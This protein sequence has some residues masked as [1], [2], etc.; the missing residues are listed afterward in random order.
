MPEKRGYLGALICAFALLAPVFAAHLTFVPDVTFKGASLAGWHVLGDA[1][2]RAQD[3]ELIGKA[4]AGSAGGWLVLDNPYQDVEVN[5]MFQCTG[6][7]RTGLL[8]RLE[9]TPEGYQGVLVSLNAG[10]VAPYQLTLDENGKEVKREELRNASG[11][12]RVAPPLD[13]N[14]AA[15][16]AGNRQARRRAEPVKLPLDLRPTE[17][18]P[19]EWNEVDVVMDANI[20]RIALNNGGGRAGVTDAPGKQFGPVA[21]FVGGTGEVRFKEFSYRDLAMQTTPLEKVSS[22]F[23]AQRVSDMYYSWSSAVA[24][25]NHDGVLDVVSG[26]VIYFGPDYTKHRE[27]LYANSFG[28]SRE[29]S[30][31]GGQFASD[32]NGDGWPDILIGPPH[33]VLYINPKG[34]SRRWDSYQVVDA[35]QSELALLADVDGDGRQDLIYGGEGCVRYATYD[36]ADPTKP[37]AIHSVS[38]NGYSAAHGLGVGDINGDGRM[39]LLNPYGWWEQPPAGSGQE[40]WPYHAVAFCHNWRRRLPAGQ[41]WEFMTSTATGSTTWSPASALT[42]TGWLGSSRSATAPATS[43]SSCT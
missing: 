13:P 8:V 40:P 20:V 10:D 11:I 5:S 12:I 22:H 18:R 39:D 15:R 17:L 38:E 21:L 34:E 35:V 29:F 27:I 31:T 41:A 1:E 30:N 25:F 3:G 28:Q 43:R 7:C 2:W 32:V 23:R 36:P 37:W 6:D 4:K 24:D 9:K 26:P 42:A 14:A 33:A 16:R 19:G